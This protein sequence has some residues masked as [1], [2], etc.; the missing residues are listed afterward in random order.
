MKKNSYMGVPVEKFQGRAGAF[1]LPASRETLQKWRKIGFRLSKNTPL[2]PNET[3]L[4]DALER[5]SQSVAKGD[6]IDHDQLLAAIAEN[7]PEANLSQL[8]MRTKSLSKELADAGVFARESVRNGRPGLTGLFA[9]QTPEKAAELYADS[10]PTEVISRTNLGKKKPGARNIKRIEDIYEVMFAHGLAGVPALDTDEPWSYFLVTQLI[11]R[12]SRPLQTDPRKNISAPITVDGE[13]V[14]AEAAAT[15]WSDLNDPIYSIVTESDAQIIL[16]ILSIAMQTMSRQINQGRPLENRI[17]IDLLKIARQLNT[18]NELHTYRTF[19]RGMTRIINTQFK[20]TAQ[21]DSKLAKRI[22]LKTGQPGERVYFRLIDHVI[23]GS[24]NGGIPVDDPEWNPTNTLRYV[25]FSLADWIWRDLFDG[26]GWVVHPGLLTERSGLTHKLYNH[27]KAHS[28][29][30]YTY[31]TTGEQLEKL[32]NQTSY[33]PDKTTPAKR[34]IRQFNNKL[35]A[36]FSE[37]ATR[38][39]GH[40]ALDSNDLLEPMDLLFFDLHVKVEPINDFKGA[41]QVSARHSE[42]SR[43]LLDIQ[44]QRQPKPQIAHPETERLSHDEG[45]T[46][47]GTVIDKK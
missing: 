43:R 41:I 26:R 16:T 33:N 6:V 9:L 12:C 2:T 17:S 7:D 14:M 35:W 18:G 31:S 11:E 47:D 40:I 4:L 22:K 19:Q 39:L 23:E 38:S 25:T 46:F 28:S 8:S 45:R 36:I 32:L 24:D 34:R 30:T 20:L 37:H 1:F 3:I 44:Q 13:V 5:A 27:L 42:E 15:V 29:A 21:P 10:S